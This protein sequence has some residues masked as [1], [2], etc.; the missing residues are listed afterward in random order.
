[1]ADLSEL[2]LI[3]IIVVIVIFY[4]WYSS[5]AV[6]RKPVT[7]RES[8]V[9]AKG[10]VHSETMAPNGEVSIEGVIWRA[11]AANQT[12]TFKKGDRIVVDKVEHLSLIVEPDKY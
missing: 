3:A 12:Q 5:S 6:R 9:G 10:F 7:G 4:I 2:L 11:R 8:L 1:M